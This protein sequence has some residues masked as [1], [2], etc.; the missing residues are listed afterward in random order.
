MATST[1]PEDAL[2]DDFLSQRGHD[3]E[4]T[5]DRSYNKLQCP[6]CGGLHDPTAT[7][8]GVCGWAP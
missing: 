1:D 5:W 6:E 7:E 3:E 2:F 4:R 8:C